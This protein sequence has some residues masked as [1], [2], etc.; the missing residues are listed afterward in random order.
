MNPLQ[1]DGNL[2]KHKQTTE[3]STKRKHSEIDHTQKEVEVEEAVIAEQVQVQVH[4]H[5]HDA[6]AH[7]AKRVRLSSVAKPSIDFTSLPPDVIIQKILPFHILFAVWCTADRVVITRLVQNNNGGYDCEV[8]NLRSKYFIPLRRLDLL[9]GTVPYIALLPRSTSAL[10]RFLFGRFRGDPTRRPYQLFNTCCLP[11][12][13]TYDPG[14]SH[15]TDDLDASY[16]DWQV[17]QTIVRNIFS[18]MTSITIPHPFADERTIERASSSLNALAIIGSLPH[19]P[20]DMSH[21]RNLRTLAMSTQSLTNKDLANIGQNCT[22]LRFLRLDTTAWSN[23]ATLNLS[24]LN[25]CKSLIGFESDHLNIDVEGLNS[26]LAAH[27]NLQSLRVRQIDFISV[28]SIE[29][30]D[31]KSVV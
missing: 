12:M 24:L 2:S 29:W 22:H 25:R 27:P 9:H 15:H 3:M 1:K 8:V 6:I 21:L 20:N 10:V 7:P 28:P 4:E 31:R 30:P 19:L 16:P 26:F 14:T 23:Q 5:E 11:M 17:Q 18:R 13:A